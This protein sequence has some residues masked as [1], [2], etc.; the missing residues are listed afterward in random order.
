MDILALTAAAASL[1]TLTVES[2]KIHFSANINLSSNVNELLT[3]RSMN[4]KSPDELTSF[5]TPQ[6]S[7]YFVSGY[8]PVYG[9]CFSVAFQSQDFFL[10]RVAPGSSSLWNC[11]AGRLVHE[12]AWPDNGRYGALATT[13][14]S[15]FS[16]K[17]CLEEIQTF[18]QNVHGPS[19]AWKPWCQLH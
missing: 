6:H 4:S 14:S 19:T 17:S 8:A 9:Y 3:A 1:T 16:E 13:S 15:R 18:H 10:L 5:I 11:R 2:A 7:N 12:P